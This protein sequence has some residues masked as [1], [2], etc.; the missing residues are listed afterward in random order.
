MIFRQL[1]EAQTSTF[2]YLLADPQTREAVLIDPVRETAE[3]DRKL[4]DELGLQLVHTLETHVHADHVTGASLLRE[5]CSSRSVV[6]RQSGAPC[7]DRLVGEGDRVH[8]GSRW[9]EV[10]ET[11]GHTDG[12]LSFVLDDRSMVFTGDTL[13]IRGTGRTDFQQGDPVK[14][15][16]SIHTKLF[17]LPDDTQVFPGHDYRGFTSSTIAEEKAHNPRVGGGRSLESFVEIMNGLQLAHPKRIAEAVPANLACGRA[18]DSQEDGQ[19]PAPPLEI[20][21]QRSEQ[22]VPEVDTEWL[23]DHGELSMS[24]SMSIVDVRGVDEW[25][26]GHIEGAKLVPLPTL[27]TCAGDWPRERPIVTICRVGSR[28]ADAA[29]QLESAGFTNVASLRGGVLAWA[30]QGRKLVR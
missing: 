20:P 17:S 25:S 27:L 29:L 16:E 5:Q 18:Q 12:C 10:R 26:E 21:A 2:T 14:L 15:Y 8:F 30:K 4:L 22:G 7:A 1:F 11:P 6:S 23:A 24:M 28:S 9:L 19:R 13:L 3:R